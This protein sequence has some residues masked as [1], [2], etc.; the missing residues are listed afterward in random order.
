MESSL[1]TLFNLLGYG[2]R[3]EGN[4]QI[5]GFKPGA[6]KR[7]FWDRSFAHFFAS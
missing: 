6:V 3:C 2:L 1:S 4:A 7:F 5:S